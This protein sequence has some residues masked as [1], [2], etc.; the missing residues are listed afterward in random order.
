MEK[1]RRGRKNSREEGGREDRE[2]GGEEGKRWKLVVE[3]AASV[4]SSILMFTSFFYSTWKYVDQ[5]FVAVTTT[6]LT[7]ALL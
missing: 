2:E 6:H 1:E 3:V 7:I 5:F 4:Y